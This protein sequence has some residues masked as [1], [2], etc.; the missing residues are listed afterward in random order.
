[1][2]LRLLFQEVAL[3]LH[4]EKISINCASNDLLHILRPFSNTP[5]QARIAL[6]MVSKKVPQK[7]KTAQLCGL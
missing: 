2:H 3:H 4:H 7:T 5:K 1:L 6:Q